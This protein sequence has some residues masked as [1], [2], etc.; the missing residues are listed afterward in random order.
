MPKGGTITIRTEKVIVGGRL[1]EGHREIEPGPYVLVSVTDTGDGMDKRTRERIFEPFFTTK[2]PGKGTGL[3]L[4]IVYGIIQQH[5]GSIRV[6]SEPGRGTTFEMLLPIIEVPSVL[7]EEVPADIPRGTEK[8]LV[9]EDNRELRDLLR[10]ILEQQGYR[11]FEAVDGLDAIDKQAQFEADLVI[12]DVVM[13][14]M[15]GRETYEAL[16]KADPS[17]RVLFMSG[18]TDDIIHQKGILDPTLNYIAKPILPG[19]LMKK[20]REALESTS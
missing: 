16:K 19:E 12:L 1:I 8:V 6:L 20:V 2:E 14:R 18:Y 7:Q 9:V 17:I 11:V 3:G 5:N 4:A 10:V 13:P 15:N